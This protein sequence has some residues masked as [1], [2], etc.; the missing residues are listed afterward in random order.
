MR[1]LSSASEPVS[2]RPGHA[3]LLSLII[4]VYN[5][6]GYLM[7]CLT[8]IAGQAFRDIEIIAVDGASTDR[9]LEVLEK[10]ATDESRL[11][12]RS[13]ERVGPGS[14]RNIGAKHA[15]GRYLWFVDGDDELA[16]D[17]LAPIASRLAAQRPD[18]LVVN[19][20][21]LTQGRGGDELKAGLDDRLIARAGSSCS[22]L[23]DRPWL[24]DLR[25]VCW[26][27]I[28]RREFFQSCGA[29]FDEAWPHEDL[30]VS[31]ALLLAAERIS[32]LDRVCYHYR[33]QR[34]GSAT[35]SGNRARHFLV[36]KRWLPILADLRN[37]TE[38]RGR[39]GDDL[40][41]RF[42]ERSI[43]HCASIL[44]ASGYIARADRREFFRRMSRL[45]RRQVPAG[46]RGPAGFPRIK[47][48]LVAR[49]LY[50]GYVLLAPLNRLRLAAE[51]SG[52][53]AGE[54]TTPSPG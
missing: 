45:Y 8:S 16:S 27:K 17:C 26:N 4:P 20:A 31:C 49:N 44:D 39:A 23:A 52:D 28:V 1:D 54:P 37:A 24:I 7:P 51:R 38:A 11:T 53:R 40:Y 42:F 18:V 21:E 19:H 12:I 25:L 13:E 22:T 48:W 46:Y 41:R 10:F 33:G 3:P 29:E 36:F 43:S 32:I 14:A 2:T 5:I 35:T 6:S 15:Q 30:P 50:A 47:F 9:S 34:P